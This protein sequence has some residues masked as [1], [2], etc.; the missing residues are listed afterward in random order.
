MIN[1][2]FVND[3]TS[4]LHDVTTSDKTQTLYDVDTKISTMGLIVCKNFKEV[5]VFW[6]FF[7]D[8]VRQVM[9]QNLADYGQDNDTWHKVEDEIVNLL[10]DDTILT[11]ENTSA[12]MNHTERYL[13]CETT[14]SDNHTVVLK[15]DV[16][17]SKEILALKTDLS[18]LKSTQVKSN[19]KPST[20]EIKT[21]E[22]VVVPNK[23]PNHCVHPHDT[24]V[25][26]SM[27]II[28]G[29]QDNDKYVQ[30]TG[31]TGHT[32]SVEVTEVVYPIL[33]E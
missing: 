16:S 18:E 8:S 1:R 27:G 6:N 29:S 31:I 7:Q 3:L 32:T 10:H 21:L 28:P 14:T 24:S 20:L 4:L 26:T 23:E 17:D 33:T 11:L 5:S 9:I 15:V 19:N 25:S 2:E 12:T 30:L 22:T 13:N